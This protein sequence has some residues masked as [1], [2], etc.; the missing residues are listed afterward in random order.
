MKTKILPL[1]TILLF[2]CMPTFGQSSKSNWSSD[3]RTKAD[4]IIVSGR[5][6]NIAEG[7]PRTLIINECDISDKSVRDICELDSNDSFCRK[8]PFSFPHSFTVNYNRRNFINVFAAPGDSIYMDIDPST[9][10]LTVTFSGD[11]EEINQQ[12]DPAFQHITSFLYSVNLPPDTVALE[13]YMPIFT[14]YVKEGRDSI[15]NYARRHHLCEEV[16]SMLY[17]DN[18][19][20]LANRAIEY[21]GRNSKE[22]Q[23]FLLNPIFDIFNEDNT[24][25]MIFPYHINAIMNHFPEVRDSAPKGIVRDIMYACDEDSPI[26][27]RSA[28]YNQRYYDRLYTQDTPFKELTID[29]IKPGSSIVYIDGEIKEI[30]DENPLKWLLNEYQGHPAYL[31]ISATW[32]GPCR[33]GLKRSESLRKNYKDSDIKFVIIWLRSDK[34]AW[35]NIAPTISNTVQIFIADAE[36]DDLITKSLSVNGFPT[37]LMIDRVGNITKAGVPGYLSPELLDFLNRYK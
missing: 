8:I 25:V 30:R 6:H 15:D 29:D 17:A 24:K 11:N 4:S 2:V 26:P 34:E 3:V 32:C 27:D 5:F 7:M 16:I 13:K 31:D 10:P 22:K 19:Y 1:L 35:L 36:M 18:V 20:S 28:F 12:Y 23:A 9:Y 14:K 37:Y 21:K 33:E